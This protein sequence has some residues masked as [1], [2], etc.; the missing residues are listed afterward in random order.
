[1]EMPIAE[2]PQSADPRRA[3]LGRIFAA[4]NSSGA[5]WCIAHGYEKYADEIPVDIDCILDRSLDST[6]AGE[7]AALAAENDLNARVV[8]VLSDGAQWIVLASN[9]PKPVILQLHVSYDYVMADRTF[10]AG[11]KILETRQPME[12][13][14]LAAPE[15][16]FACI[17]VNRI[18]KAKF[19]ERR[20]E[21]LAMLF[22]QAPD[23]CNAEMHNLLSA[24]NQRLIA[25]SAR[26]GNWDAGVVAD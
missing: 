1:M 16:E 14:W 7:S 24:D 23:R 13:F 3:L 8:Q 10:I 11:E 19:D 12:D 26:T 18:S 9:D 21:R 25:M 2:V 6:E 20:Q 5:P 15:M 17:L 22:A 4:L